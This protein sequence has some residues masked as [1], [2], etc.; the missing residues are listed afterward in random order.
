MAID[1]IIDHWHNSGTG[2][3]ETHAIGQRLNELLH[4]ATLDGIAQTIQF[5]EHE[6]LLHI[7][8]GQAFEIAPQLNEKSMPLHIEARHLIVVAK[9]LGEQWTPRKNYSEAS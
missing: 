6:A 7:K 8:R 9:Q 3:C 4:V 5:F 1:V 2:R